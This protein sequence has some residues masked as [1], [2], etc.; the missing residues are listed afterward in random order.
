VK[1]PDILIL[2]EPASALDGLV[3]RA[4]FDALPALLRSRT[5]F[6]VAHRPSTIQHADRILLLN[7]R[8]LLASGTHQELLETNAYYRSLMAHPSGS[9]GG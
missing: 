4:I 6:V 3:E 8:R 1:D 7:E 9:V 2:D 5:L